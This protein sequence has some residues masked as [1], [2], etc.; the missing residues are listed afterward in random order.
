MK[1]SSREPPFKINIRQLEYSEIKKIHD[2]L[3]KW[4]RGDTVIVAEVDHDQRV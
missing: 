1:H 3:R 2:E 4:T